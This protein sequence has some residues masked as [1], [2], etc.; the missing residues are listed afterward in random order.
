MRKEREHYSYK[1]YK[2]D[3]NQWYFYL[4]G[5][6]LNLPEDKRSS[7]G[8][9]AMC[10]KHKEVIDE[11]KRIIRKERNENRVKAKC[12]AYFVEDSKE[13]YFTRDL[14]FSPSDRNRALY[15]FK[16]WKNHIIKNN[17][18]LRKA[19]TIQEGIITPFGANKPKE[20]VIEDKIDLSRRIFIKLVKS[21]EDF[22]YQY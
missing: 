21:K 17:C 1:G 2:Y 4:N 3:S 12:I 22:I 13:Y 5:K 7:L 20:T 18:M 15:C 10:G 14:S 19:V 8:Y 6:L 11:L 16:E 9:L